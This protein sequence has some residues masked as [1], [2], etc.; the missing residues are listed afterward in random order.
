[1]SSLTAMQAQIRATNTEKG[2]RTLP[3]THGDRLALIHSEI[4]EALEEIR[5][6]HAP[7]EIYFGENGKPEGYPVE[8]ADA[9]IRI[10]DEIDRLGLDA[11]KVLQMKMD[12]NS[13]RPHLHGGKVL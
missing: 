11:E 13:T 1:M 12:F 3:T 9:A 7:A 2:F 5:S 8:L 4:S 6:G 10:I